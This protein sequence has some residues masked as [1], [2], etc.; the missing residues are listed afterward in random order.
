MGASCYTGGMPTDFDGPLDFDADPVTDFGFDALRFDTLSLSPVP[1]YVVVADAGGNPIWVP[2]SSIAAAGAVGL[3]G[4]I[5][6][7]GREGPVGPMGERGPPGKDGI[8]GIDGTNGAT[9]A[10]G[11]MGPP[12]PE[13]P[14][15]PE[16]RM[17][18][19]G[20][21]GDT[22]PTGAT[23]STG[24]TGA[25][26][27]AV[28]DAKPGSPN[29]MDDEFDDTSGMSGPVNGLNA[30]WTWRNQGSAS[31][32]FPS[33]GGMRILLPASAT[34]NTRILEQAV[35][36]G[37]FTF[38]AKVALHSY[39]ANFAN[40]GIVVIDRTNDDFYKFGLENAATATAAGT[41]MIQQYWTNVTT[42][43]SALTLRTYGANQVYLRA[44]R[45]SGVLEFWY[46]T[47][48]E[49][50]INFGTGL[51]GIGETGVGIFANNENNLT[52]QWGAFKWFRR[53]A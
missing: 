49:D 47:N 39:S 19:R 43:S 40:A 24:A 44:M 48:G 35:A 52:G 9:G 41:Y 42:F 18:P 3:T 38:E 53:T 29:A 30:R 17:G 16:G 23:G 45:V 51:G 26:G 50:W 4:P 15:G 27:G 36:A 10:T 37:D 6:P 12:G 5:G 25:P 14:M 13:G 8:I 11:V 22:G 21:T 1:G 28:A 20:L 34:T 33:L 7:P 2:A 32:S 46:S 31:V